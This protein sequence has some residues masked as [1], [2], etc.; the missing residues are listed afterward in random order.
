MTGRILVV[1]DLKANVRLLE[2][3]L[4]ADYFE[5]KSAASGEEALAVIAR[6]PC[7]VV[8]LDVMMPGLDGFETCRRLKA[9]ARTAH[10]PVVMI[11]ALDQI[12]DRI[13]GF[14]AGADDFLSKPISD[15]AL[16]TRVRNL[17][18]LKRTTD[19]LRLRAQTGT[20]LGIA[21]ECDEDRDL[22]ARLLLVDDRASS[23]GRIAAMLGTDHIVD[24]LGEPQQAPFRA[25]E[26]SYDAVLISLSLGNFDPLRLCS[27]L[28]DV[29]RTRQLPIMVMAEPED[30]PRVMRALE[31]G[32]NDYL[33]RPVDP[34]ELKLRLRS[35]V[36][37]KRANERLINDVQQTIA[38]AATD[39]LTGLYNRR[40]LET[41]L[42]TLVRQ[43][44]ERS[45]DLSVLTL[46]IDYFKAVNDTHGHD[47]GD[48]VL[49]EFAR[50]IRMNIRGLDL[51]CRFGGEEFVIVM[52]ETDLT[53]AN[54]VAERIRRLMAA[55]GF[56]IRAGTEALDIT[57]SVGVASYRGESDT[58][59]EILKRSDEALYAAKREGRNRVVTKAA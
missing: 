41:H 36:M 21:E 33:L 23:S 1:D 6:W 55:T 9:D 25:A 42:K 11:T 31:L 49:R 26:H 7:D 12:G 50:R 56:P 57:V 51:A 58:P 47:A 4:L 27:Q 46:D 54:K 48:D 32:V 37:R 29:E 38:L 28:R 3:R 17:I 43:S 24:I 45:V 15:V 10:V 20:A 30:Q 34:T 13:K 59:D 2:A 53:L 14:E 16:V 5:V 39:A 22:R 19:E 44:R 18:A 40:Y 52:P 8:L 35:Q